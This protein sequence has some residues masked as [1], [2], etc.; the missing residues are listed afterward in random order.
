[1]E[2]PEDSRATG[3]SLRRRGQVPAK[4][5]IHAGLDR[6]R[7]VKRGS[8]PRRC[9]RTHFPTMYGAPTYPPLLA[10]LQAFRFNARKPRHTVRVVLIHFPFMFVMGDIHIFLKGS[11]LCLCLTI[12]SSLRCLRADGK[13]SP[14]GRLRWFSKDAKAECWTRRCSLRSRSRLPDET[15]FHRNKCLPGAGRQP[16]DRQGRR[17]WYCSTICNRAH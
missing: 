4:S 3:A 7:F 5:T 15:G 17:R 9:R 14:T 16:R 1:M 12:R 13:R 6:H 10:A 8:G 11:A 2:R